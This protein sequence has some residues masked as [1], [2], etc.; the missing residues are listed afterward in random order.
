MSENG[1]ESSNKRPRQSNIRYF[2]VTDRIEKGDL[3]VAF[4]LTENILAH[5]FTKLLQGTTFRRM[6]DR[7]L[8]TP[9][10]KKKLNCTG[11]S[12]NNEITTTRQINK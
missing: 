3:K 8:D 12:W 1:W 6:W 2:F 4:C 9:S 10:N 7:I 5:F 11:V